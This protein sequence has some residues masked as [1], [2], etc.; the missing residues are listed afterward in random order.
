MSDSTPPRRPPFGHGKSGPAQ[1]KF[2]VVEE[3]A[4]FELVEEKPKKALRAEPEPDEEPKPQKPR[5]KKKK[6]GLSL[7]DKLLEGQDEDQE[8]RDAALRRYE[9]TMP[10]VLLGIGLLLSVVGAFGASK[11]VSGLFTIGALTLFVLI[12]VPLAIAALMVVGTLMGINYGRL[13]PAILKMSA[14]TFVANGIWLIG[15]WMRIPAFFIFPI[16]CFISFGLFMTQFDLDTWETNASAG[17]LNVMTFAANMILIAFLVASVSSSGDKGTDKD[18]DATP[19]ESQPDRKPKRERENLN[20]VK[21]PA[22]PGSPPPV[23]DP[24]DE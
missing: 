9:Y 12:Y 1:P 11:G 18:D 4:D 22:V 13:W 15:E 2:E 17:A 10:A 8:R 19:A 3:D 16:S 23:M 14:I 24:D 5:K 6:K 21:V 20:G 7:A